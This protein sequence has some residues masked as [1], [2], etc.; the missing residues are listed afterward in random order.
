M[1][2]SQLREPLSPPIPSAIPLKSLDEVLQAIFHARAA[3][4]RSLHL[5]TLMQRC[6]IAAQRRT[7]SAEIHII[8]T[9]LLLHGVTI[10]AEAYIRMME[11]GETAPRQQ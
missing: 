7:F 5:A 4:T 2:P 3:R 9:R 10:R 11:V 1:F 8:F 6:F